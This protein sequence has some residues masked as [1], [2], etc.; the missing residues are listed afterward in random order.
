MNKRTLF[1]KTEDGLS[2]ETKKADEVSAK[3]ELVVTGEELLKMNVEELPF[4]LEGIIP[5]VGVAALGGASDMGKSSLLRQFVIAVVTA[6]TT[7]L[8]FK[9]N[10]KHKRALY[11][12]TED[13]VMAVVH[14]IPEII[15][16][17]ALQ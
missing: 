17:K 14:L 4:L 6:Q 9:L 15:Y 16:N 5:T 11:I 3:N 13:D 2:K 12:S 7:F 1:L 10:L 8:G